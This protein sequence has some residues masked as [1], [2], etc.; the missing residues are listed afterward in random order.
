VFTDINESKVYQVLLKLLQLFFS[1]Y[2][3]I[4]G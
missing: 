3:T 1:C 2:V 4:Q